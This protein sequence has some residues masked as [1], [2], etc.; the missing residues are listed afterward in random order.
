DA[1][2]DYVEICLDMSGHW[3]EVIPQSKLI[4]LC[5]VVEPDPGLGNEA[6]NEAVH[7]AALVV[8]DQVAAA[9][10][11][12]TPPERELFN[13][14]SVNP[15]LPSVIYLWCVHSPQ[16]MSGSP[17][18]FCTMTYGLT[19]LT[20]PWFLHPNEILDG[21]LSGPYRTA[22]AMSWTVVNNPILLDLYRRHGVDWNFLGVISLRTEWTTQHEKQLMAN[23]TAK[24]AQ[25][26]GAKGA[27]ITWDAGGNEFIEVVRTI[28]ACE[29]L[30]I[31]TVFLTSEDDATEA[32]PTMLEPLPEANAIVS[33][34]FFKTSTLQTPELQPVDRV[35]GLP[36][37][38]IGPL[39]DQLVPTA[40]A[41]PPPPRFDD[42]YGFGSL[43][44]IEY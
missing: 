7:K 19:Q 17:T 28:Q 16:A 29:Q 4:N 33:T 13:I 22:F 34:S 14:D 39:R 36:Q 21:A 10:R 27:I 42:H 3:A 38:A 30:G 8:N 5:L 9:T 25:H 32:A 41:L 1:G 15:N 26:L 31:K 23:Q 12:L 2:G 11:D 37:K 40:G 6:Q 43:S 18:A 20:P 44:C 24:L 35:I